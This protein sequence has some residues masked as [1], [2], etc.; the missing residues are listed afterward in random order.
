MTNRKPSKRFAD[1][2]R[3]LGTLFLYIAESEPESELNMWETNFEHLCGT[4]ACHAGWFGIANNKSATESDS[5]E[6]EANEMAKFLGFKD[7]G[8]FTRRAPFK[9]LEQWAAYNAELWG[10]DYGEDM[11]TIY[12]AFSPPT[13]YLLTRATI[14]DVGLYW[15]AVGDRI[16][17]AVKVK[18]N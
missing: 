15:I 13:N 4:V 2:A 12:A 17:A 1:K 18:A 6:D 5:F 16:E 11:F 7:S 10:N 14:K 9:Q 3:T 8:T